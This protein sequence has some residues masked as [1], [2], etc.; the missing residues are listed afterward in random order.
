MTKLCHDL[1][2]LAHTR[3]KTGIDATDGVAEASAD[4]EA[5]V[6]REAGVVA[7]LDFQRNLLARLMGE[8]PDA[9]RD[10]VRRDRFSDMIRCDDGAGETSEEVDLATKILV[11]RWTCGKSETPLFLGRR[12]LH[13]LRPAVDRFGHSGRLRIGN[14]WAVEGE[15]DARA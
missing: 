9:G 14:V 8:G 12:S 6:K 1:L 5:A 13:C 15:R 11:I 2:A 4:L 3:F 10:P 7:Q